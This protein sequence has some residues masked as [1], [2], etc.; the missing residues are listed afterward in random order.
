MEASGIRSC[1]D[2]DDVSESGDK[3]IMN[4]SLE[5]ARMLLKNLFTALV[6]KELASERTRVRV[7]ELEIESESKNAILK[8]LAASGL[9]Q[10]S[11][12]GF[13]SIGRGCRSSDSASWRW[14]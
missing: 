14:R 12:H 10:G 3:L 5:E 13:E 9:S 2:Q 8:S 6:R 7:K 1:L 11:G 4:A